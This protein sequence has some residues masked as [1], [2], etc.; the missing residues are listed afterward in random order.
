VW[1]GVGGG[2]ETPP[3]HH[4]VAPSSDNKLNL[5][6]KKEKKRKGKNFLKLQP[7]TCG[8]AGGG[9]E[10]GV[11]VAPKSPGVPWLQRTLTW[12]RAGP[13]TLTAGNMLEAGSA[14]CWSPGRSVPMGVR[15][16]GERVWGGPGFFAC[17]PLSIPPAFPFP[18]LALRMW[19]DPARP[20]RGEP[21]FVKGRRGGGGGGLSTSLYPSRR[22]QVHLH[23]TPPYS[24]IDFLLRL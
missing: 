8:R 13:E 9:A 10:R 1:G 2:R 24:T 23:K 5:K 12:G 6:K 17:K 7:E 14:S 3:A 15:T 19:A 16:P 21:R 11:W 4:Q 22:P 18:S 20:G